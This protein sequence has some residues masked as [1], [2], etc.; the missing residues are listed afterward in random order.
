MNVHI[1]Q[2]A[3]NEQ[4]QNGKMKDERRLARPFTGVD[5]EAM[6]DHTPSLESS[7]LLNPDLPLLA[8]PPP[9][10]MVNGDGPQQRAEGNVS[11][12]IAGHLVNGGWGWVGRWGCGDVQ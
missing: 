9:P 6:A 4:V 1:T 7:R 12:N 11:Q 10:A 5:E 3:E 2:G 8:P